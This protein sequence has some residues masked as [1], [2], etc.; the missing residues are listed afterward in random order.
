MT[1]RKDGTFFI[2]T[3]RS[4]P[5]LVCFSKEGFLDTKGRLSR[6]RSQRYKLC[7]LSNRCHITNISVSYLQSLDKFHLSVFV[8]RTY[9]T[10]QREKWYCLLPLFSCI[11][12]ISLSFSFFVFFFYIFSSFVLSSCLKLFLSSLI[13]AFLSVLGFFILSFFHSFV[14]PFNICMLFISSFHFFHWFVLPFFFCSSLT[15][16][17]LSP[18]VFNV[19]LRLVLIEKTFLSAA[20]R[21]ETW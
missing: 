9:F 20:Q 15:S 21:S 1:R 11:I 10:S 6:W 2:L 19:F 13:P 7:P 14:F 3:Q 18:I 4:P 5:K 8:T 17:W 16:F 12:I